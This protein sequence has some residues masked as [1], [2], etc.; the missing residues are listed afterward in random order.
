MKRLFDIL[1]S[2]IVLMIFLPF[3]ILISIAIICES[4]GGVFYRQQRVGKNGVPFRLWKF[5][6][7]RVN[8]DKLGKLTV[9]MRDPR[10][11]RVGYFIRKSKLDEFP[12]FINVLS[13]EMSIV[14]PRPEVQEYVDLYTPEQREVLSVKPGITDYA[15]LE[16]FKENE[17]LGKSENPR[18]TYIHEIM[19][20]KIALNKKY[21]AN[22]TLSQD[23]KIMWQTFLKMVK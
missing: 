16:Y 2:F 11:T 6:T 1:V 8:A 21:I 5:R 3:G 4:R 18:E 7:M 19:P 14:G 23:I 15:S 20:A 17:L 12:Q 22:P 13:G 9:G 10:I